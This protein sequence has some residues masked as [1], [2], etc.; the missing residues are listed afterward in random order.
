VGRARDTEIAV[1]GGGGGRG[2]SRMQSS[3]GKEQGEGGDERERLRREL[4]VRG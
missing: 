4:G 1:C 3:V 2:S